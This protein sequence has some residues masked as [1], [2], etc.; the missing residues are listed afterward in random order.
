[1]E[2]EPVQHRRLLVIV[3]SDPRTSGRLAEAVRFAAGVSAWQ[4][5]DVTLYVGGDAVRGLLAGENQFVD[6]DNIVDF[7]PLL[8]EHRQELYVERDHPVV[9]NHRDLIPYPELNV[10]QLASLATEHDFIMRF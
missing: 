3:T 5:V 9:S 8:A 4:K 6:E 1:M 7:L 2:D 10:N